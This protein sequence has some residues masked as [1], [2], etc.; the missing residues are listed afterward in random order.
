MLGHRFL[1]TILFFIF[2]IFPGMLMSESQLFFCLAF[3]VL[4]SRINNLNLACFSQM[5]HGLDLSPIVHFYL[6]R[7]LM[8]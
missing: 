7:Q 5:R 3:Q 1:V 4:H 6:A 8:L 2:F